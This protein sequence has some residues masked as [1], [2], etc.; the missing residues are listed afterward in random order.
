MLDV[1]FTIDVEVWCDG[2]DDIDRKF[3]AAF[4]HYIYGAGGRYGLPDQL[5][6]LDDH[7]LKSVCFVEPL[8]AGRFGMAPL[9]EIIG[10]IESRGHEIQLHLH[11]EWANEARQPLPD[12]ENPQR[13]RQHLFHYTL[14]E[15]TRLIAVGSA[16][17]QAAGADMPTAFRAGS[18]ALNADT[19]QALE[20]NAIYVDAS[21]NAST[22]GPA[23]G[24]GGGEILL[25][26]RQIGS[27]L[28]LPMTVYN[29]GVGLRHAQ[30]T[31][32]SWSE[33]E[34]LLWQALE[35]QQ[36]T[37]VILS[38][39]FELLTA[40][41]TAPDPVV[42]RRLRK[43]CAFLDRHRDSF[44]VRGLCDQPLPKSVPKAGPGLHSSIWRTSAR[45]LEQA[46]RRRYG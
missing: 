36:D 25:L 20:A 32:C 14:A 17:L 2:W 45:M 11:T 16:W 3:P 27:V 12:I 38:H 46:G 41:Q 19:L 23:S 40:R 9:S 4:R 24:V 26:P 15:Q 5:A 29:D 13:K 31:A 21:Y 30:L 22:F 43:L 1:F 7:G 33:L 44:R 35:Q 10:L 34:H 8:F 39:S 6:I 37:F 28:E 42:I 18:F